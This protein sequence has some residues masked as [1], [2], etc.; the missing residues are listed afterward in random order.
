[1]VRKR[2]SRTARIVADL[3]KLIEDGLLKPGDRLPSIRA[4]ADQYGIAKNSMVEVYD[5]LVALGYARAQHGSGFFVTALHRPRP[6]E[7]RPPHIAEAVDLVWLLREQLDQKYVARVGDGR[8][9]P[10]WT[11][12][13]EL[14]RYLRPDRQRDAQIE[15]GYGSPLGFAP[16]RE[17]LAVILAERSI[18]ASP[19][20]I[21]L[22]HGANHALDIIVR[23]LIEPGDVVLVDE[24]GY[25]PLYA[26]LKLAKAEMVG[27][28]RN[29]DGPDLEDL[30]R[31]AAGGRAKVF[32]TQSLAHNPTGNSI[33]LSNAHR[34]LQ[35]AMRHD[36]LVIDDDPFADLMPAASPRLAALDQLD[37]VIYVS[38][39]SKTL[40]ASLRCG[41]VA[42]SPKIIDA[43]TDVKM[44][45][46]VNSSGYIE[47]IVHDLIA[48]GQHRHHLRRLRQRIQTASA[49]AFEVLDELG[50]PVF[51]APAGGYY[52]WGRL[53]DHV[54]DLEFARAA[55]AENI[56]VSPGSV[57]SPS[58]ALAKPHMRINIAYVNDARFHDFYRRYVGT[59]ARMAN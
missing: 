13:S 28:R 56:F 12:G 58:R 41:Y 59:S 45:S 23:H 48:S 21:L 40:S 6:V 25:Y 22:T 16:L 34:V 10:S 57:F 7:T 3:V 2:L 38:S 30:E 29:V 8:P 52:V 35:I 1:M 39:F 53:P 42:A 54:N 37:R 19:S 5:R 27:V 17:R 50:I 55:A 18:E 46:V 31:K 49:K 20:Q 51:G 47:H 43:L 11:E 33:T 32:F 36:L 15:T 4:G 44:L 14:R 9:P 24:P 26:K